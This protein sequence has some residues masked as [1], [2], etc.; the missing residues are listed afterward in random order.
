MKKKMLAC[1]VGAVALLFVGIKV[2][3][4][5]DPLK[6]LPSFLKFNSV[7]AK[8]VSKATAG[9]AL[10]A[11]GNA[12]TVWGNVEGVDVASNVAGSPVPAGSVLT[13]NGAGKCVFTAI[14][15]PTGAAGGDLEGSYPNPTLKA[16]ILPTT[17]PPSGVAGGVLSGTYPNPTLAAGIIPT[18]LPPSG[19]AG[20]GL[21]GTYP[22][23]TLVLPQN[24]ST[25]D[26][27]TFAG[28]TL[29]GSLNF[30]AGS[31]APSSISSSPIFG[32]GGDNGAGT[33]NITVAATTTLTQDMY[34]NNLTVNSGVVL[35]TGGFRIFVRGT[36]T[37]T[38]TAIIRNNGSNGAGVGG[39]G[40]PSGTVG[41]GSAG[42]S[43]AINAVGGAGTVLNNSLGGMGGSGGAS[44]NIGGVAGTNT[45]PATADG[46]TQVVQ[47]LPNALTG[48]LLSNVLATGG[49]GGGG[50]GTGPS[51]GAGGGGGGGGGVVMIAA[52]R[53]GGTGSIQANGGNGTSGPSGGGGGGGGCVIIVTTGTLP[54]TITVTASGGN[55]GAGGT[56]LATAGAAGKVVIL[57]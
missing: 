35:N 1:I 2:N 50:G 52:R 41:G 5:S 23:P 10:L 8:G 20:G 11:N 49:S 47:A 44:G 45:T 25:T 18:T 48:R 28:L 13:S 24:L 14:G 15:A 30:P 29:T 3:A 34:A 4:I 39:P 31:V 16:G 33:N 12:G 53:F 42:G 57:F 27:P 46:G 22:N 37:L 9:Q 51:M 32:E 54:G 17:L 7:T 19:P 56:T 26:S 43:G 36:C 6:K 38:G 21:S 55:P 40:A